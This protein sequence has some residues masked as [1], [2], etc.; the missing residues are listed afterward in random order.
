MTGNLVTGGQW[1]SIILS[2]VQQTDVNFAITSF[3]IDFAGGNVTARLVFNAVVGQTYRI[4]TSTN[5]TTWTDNSGDILPLGESVTATSIP[6]TAGGSRFWR[7]AAVAP[8][9]FALP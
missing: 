8:N 2:G 4:Q 9:P 6:V 7:M 3:N 5:L 1:V